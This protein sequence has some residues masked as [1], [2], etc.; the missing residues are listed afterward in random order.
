MATTATRIRH[1]FDNATKIQ[2]WTL[3]NDEAGD[4]GEPQPNHTDFVWHAWGVWAGASVAIEGTTETSEAPE[5]A[6]P[7]HTPGEAILIL[8]DAAGGRM[9]QA[10]SAPYRSRPRVYGGDGTTLLTIRRNAVSR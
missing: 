1:P 3:A 8:T 10:L 4:W 9:K 7:L 5:H 6:E 2:E